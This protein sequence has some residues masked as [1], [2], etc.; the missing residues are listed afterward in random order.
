[1]WPGRP[2]DPEDPEDPEVPLVP[3]SPL[4]PVHAKVVTNSSLTAKGLEALLS[5]GETVTAK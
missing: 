2:E 5:T 1:M 3:D 4:S